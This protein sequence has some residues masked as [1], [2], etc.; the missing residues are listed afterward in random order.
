MDDAVTAYL[1]ASEVCDVDGVLATLTPDAE[2][3]SPVSGRMVFRGREDLRVLIGAVYSSLSALR[4]EKRVDGDGVTYAMAIARVG[5]LRIGDAMIFELD[6]ASGLIKRIRP[7]LRPW[8]GL[9]ALA[10]RLAPTI[11]RRPMIAVRAL[12]AGR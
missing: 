9:S 11:M 3:V 10:L 12:R 5:P 8:L 2:L 1:A 6:P 7:H 4:W